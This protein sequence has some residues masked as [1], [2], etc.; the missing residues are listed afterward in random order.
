MDGWEGSGLGKRRTGKDNGTRFFRYTSSF[1][2][3]T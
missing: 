3:G 1:C 2:V